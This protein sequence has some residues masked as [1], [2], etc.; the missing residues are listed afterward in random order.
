MDASLKSGVIIFLY[1]LTGLSRRKQNRAGNK[2]S[3]LIIR[4]LSCFA[5]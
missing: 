2:K 1:L 3:P 5:I 4:G